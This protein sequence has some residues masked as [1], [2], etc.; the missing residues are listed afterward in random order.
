MPRYFIGMYQP[1]GVVPP[2]DVLEPVMRDMGA[3]ITELREAGSL[4]FSNGFDQSVSP[5]VVTSDGTVFETSPGSY[6]V[7]DEQLGG[8]SVVEVAD[9]AAAE[10]IAVRMAEITRL[11]IE[12]RLF[13]AQG[14]P[15]EG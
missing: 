9:E 14:S 1:P 5:V 7:S 13:A 12:V 15:D 6:V 8:F 10:A 4:V 2:P 3:L 11:P